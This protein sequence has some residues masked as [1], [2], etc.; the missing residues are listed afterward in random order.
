MTRKRIPKKN[1][2]ERMSGM[3]K[4]HSNAPYLACIVILAAAAAWFALSPHFEKRQ[5]FDR[6]NELLESIEYG[7]GAI[8]ADRGIDSIS[9][10]FYDSGGEEP[11]T[12]G[13]G[14][15]G[16]SGI[17][18]SGET[19]TEENPSVI[20]FY[21]DNAT[22]A[23]PAAD[24]ANPIIEGIGILTIEKIDVRLPVTDGVTEAQLKVA[25]GH[26]PQSA[27]IGGDGNAIIAGHRSYTYGQYFNRLGE[28][29]PGDTIKYQP[30]GGAEMAFEVYEI[31]TV[32]PDAPAVYEDFPGEQILTLHT[33]TPIRVATHRLLVRAKL[34]S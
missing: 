34:I 6:Q 4:K 11:V 33:C 2:S 7:G 10:D 9:V 3:N 15:P 31:L 32:L 28:L 26:V 12:D 25:V 20:V 5:T 19:V 14:E 18:Q 13:A 23:A 21:E 29:E 24:G 8:V 17:A 30:K 27:P 22:A 16:A 1:R